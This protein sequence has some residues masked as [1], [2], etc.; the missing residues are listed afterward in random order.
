MAGGTQGSQTVVVEFRDVEVMES[1][2]TEGVHHHFPKMPTKTRN[3][4]E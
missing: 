3:F 1:P 4:T 2:Q